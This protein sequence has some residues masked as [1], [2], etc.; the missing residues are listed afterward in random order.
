MTEWAPQPE[1]VHAV[2]PTRNGGAPFDS[3]ST[4]TETQVVSLINN[5]VVEILSEVG[6]IPDELHDGAQFAAILGAAYYIEA[7]MAPEQQTDPLAPAGRL[8]TRYREQ[9]ER[10][11][12]RRSEV[13][14]G[15]FVGAMSM[16]LTSRRFPRLPDAERLAWP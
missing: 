1:A 3:E 7:G 6:S 11:K 5:T 2:I 9:V 4:P 8:F 12:L 13:V 14:G 15:Q 16:P 10:L